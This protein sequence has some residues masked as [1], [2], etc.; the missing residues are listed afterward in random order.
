[1]SRTSCRWLMIAAGCWLACANGAPADDDLWAA[2]DAAAMTRWV[3]ELLLER[4]SQAGVEP[5]G[6]SD[7][8]EFLRRAWLD[9]NGVIPTASDVREFLGDIR[10]EKR[11]LAVERLLNSPRY[12]THLANVWSNMLL[13]ADA[14]IERIEQTAQFNGWLRRRFAEN[15]R[16]DTLVAD[17]LTTTGE[18][19]RAGAVLFY[20]AAEVKPE[21]LAASTSRIFL[22]VQIQCAQCHDHP[23]DEWKQRD[24]WSYAA[25][26]ARLQ[27][28]AGGGPMATALVDA[29]RGEVMLPDS[30]E[31][32]LPKYL[33][34]EPPREDADVNRR[35][36]L[37]IWMVSRDNPYFARV[38]VNR[39][40]A[41]LFGRGLVHPVD[42]FGEHNPASHPQLLDELAAWFV[43]A[44][45]DLRALYGV[46]ANTEAYQRTSRVDARESA[47][48]APPELFSRMAIKT[49][50]PDQLY[51]C[52]LRATRFAEAEQGG[53]LGP[54]SAA[55]LN[56]RQFLAR[57]NMGTHEAVEFQAGI[58]QVLA[59]MNGP[60]TARATDP[61]QG[62]VLQALA[63]PFFSD[64]ERVE[65]LFLATLS[66]PPGD[67]ERARFVE[68]VETGGPTADRRRA[69]GDLL[70]ALLNSPE[71]VFNH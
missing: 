3:D 44:G 10:S 66:R 2:P 43:A 12:A 69:L 57:F 39:V 24:F 67:A 71:F 42:D 47:D 9:V 63:A 38:A 58:P 46:L 7:D 8:A 53:G 1:M 52:L 65:S 35:R 15:T 51:D 4:M 70:W 59:L 33:G 54:I 13:P 18:G 48:E 29:P 36:Q 49:L 23:F 17:L 26:F 50:T 30:E 11:A 27:T 19:D 62:G 16:Y 6:Q 20:T 21:E 25:F 64:G 32:V 61:D 14:Q 5:A 40:W 45:Y 55:E 41:Q 37:A 68:Y 56:R 28:S 31:V 60:L 22:G 34:A